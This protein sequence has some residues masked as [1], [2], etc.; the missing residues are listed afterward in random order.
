MR[1]LIEQGLPVVNNLVDINNLVSLGTAL[2]ISM[3][4]ADKLGTPAVI[5]FG[6]PRECYIFNVS[7]QSMD[8]SGIPVICRAAD[9]RTR[10]QRRQGFDAGQGRARDPQRARGRLRIHQARRWA[11]GRCRPRATDAARRV[12]LCPGLRVEH[13]SWLGSDRSQ[14]VRRSRVPSTRNHGDGLME[15]TVSE[16]VECGNSFGDAVITRALSYEPPPRTRRSSSLKPAG[17]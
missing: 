13:H 5:R 10:G 16:L 14:T 3:F 9:R 8:V 6:R 4:D 7:G 17:A 12:R 15:F 11:P 1:V 2:P